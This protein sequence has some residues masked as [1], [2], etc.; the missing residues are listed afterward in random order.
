MK[1]IGLYIILSSIILT[2]AIW[3]G[4]KWYFGDWFADPYKYVAKTASLSATIA[5]S[6]SMILSAR[7][8]FVEKWFGGLDKV[9]T[10]HKWLGIGGFW[11][12]FLHPLFL[13]LHKLP[14]LLTF[15][16]YFGLRP[17]DTLKYVGF[18]LGLAS[19]L[20]LISLILLIRNPKI[21]YHT[22]KKTHEFMSLFYVAV[23]LHVLL[24]DA[25]I[26][27]YPLL[28]TWMYLWFSVS[29]LCALYKTFLYGKFGPKYSYIISEIQKFPDMIELYLEP[30]TLEKLNYKPGQFVYVDFKNKHFPRELHPYSIASAPNIE[31]KIKL[32]IKKLGDYTNH[33]EMLEIGDHVNVFGAYGNFA[34][35]FLQSKRDCVCIGGGIGITPF[36]GIWDMA[37]NSDE[38][39]YLDE[40]YE[41]AEFHEEAVKA[42]KSPR[43]HQ[44][45]S[46]KTQ[47]EAIFDDNFRQSMI[48]G[49]YNGFDEYDKRGHSYT[50][51]NVGTDGYLT[52]EKIE[53]IVGKLEDKW[54]MLCGPKPMTEGLIKQ[55]KEKGI[56]N[57]QIICE[58]FTMREVDISWIYRI[59]GIKK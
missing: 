1:R 47:E 25:D 7:F 11:L 56:K 26:A 38:R 32:G 30:N 39:V 28:G 43:V 12:I 50:L 49:R 13:G 23:I 41:L 46:V 2:L 52:L 53:K 24:V 15:I 51:H 48:K 10:A 36:L 3:I 58:E 17:F 44:F 14:D 4:S 19:L 57:N 37:L 59:L 29:L 8:S 42:W 55:L 40:S 18:N 35:K 33:I 6:W 9:Y 22:W 54:F 5:F 45:Y 31:G 20:L 27:K 34:E 21:P 16:T